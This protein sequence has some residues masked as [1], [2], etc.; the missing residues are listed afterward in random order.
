MKNFAWYQPIIQSSNTFF[1]TDEISYIPQDRIECSVLDDLLV[2]I[3]QREIIV[4]GNDRL[5]ETNNYEVLLCC[6]IGDIYR[7]EL[8]V[9]FSPKKGFDLNRDYQYVTTEAEI[10][11]CDYLRENLKL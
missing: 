11:F 5:E 3:V 1:L 6:P 2:L 4:N 9:I 8:A 10:A 7:E